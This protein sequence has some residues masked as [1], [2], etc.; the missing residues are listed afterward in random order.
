MTRETKLT[1]DAD[2]TIRHRETGKEEN[3]TVSG[4]CA[5]WHWDDSTRDVAEYWAVL[6]WVAQ[7]FGNSVDWFSIRSWAGTPER[8]LLS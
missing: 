5:T 7:T 8:E 3:L 1:I 2:I 6:D 4:I